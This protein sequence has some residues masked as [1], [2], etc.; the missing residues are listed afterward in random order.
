MTRAPVVATNGLPERF[1]EVTEL[2]RL[3]TVELAE[4]QGL[5]PP[6]V[7]PELVETPV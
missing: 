4:T 6:M 7:R 5:Y 1:E 2:R 3:S